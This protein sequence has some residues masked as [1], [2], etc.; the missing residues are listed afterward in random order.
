MKRVEVLQRAGVTPVI[1]FDGG[2]LPMKAEEEAARARRV[3]GLL[4]YLHKHAIQI[5]ASTTGPGTMQF[6]RPLGLSGICSPCIC[7]V[8]E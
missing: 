3:L 6:R 8:H 4:C 7:Q 2:R 1:V 5:A